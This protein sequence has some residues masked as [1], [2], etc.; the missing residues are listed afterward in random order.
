[1][2]NLPFTAT[3]F[4]V[5]VV[6]V[7][8]L[9]VRRR[10][11]QTT[12]KDTMTIATNSNTPT[13]TPTMIAKR[14]VSD[15]AVAFPLNVNE[16][17]GSVIEETDPEEEE[18]GEEDDDDDE[19]AD[20]GVANNDDDDDDDDNVFDVDDDDDDGNVN[21]RVVFVVDSVGQGKHVQFFKQFEKQLL[22]STSVV[23][24]ML[25]KDVKTRRPKRNTA[26]HHCENLASM[27]GTT[28]SR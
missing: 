12:T 6:V 28:P 18:E 22:G 21:V 25:Q 14:A 1:L 16:V 5:V 27:N 11:R 3:A 19:E 17:V 13:A 26:S 2:L 15:D 8:V 20:D 4:D 7:D 9:V 23:S 10:R 24:K